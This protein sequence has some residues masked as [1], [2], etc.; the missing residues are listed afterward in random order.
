MKSGDLN[1]PKT[2]FANLLLDAFPDS[3]PRRFAF[4]LKMGSPNVVSS[5]NARPSDF[6]R[7]KSEPVKFPRTESVLDCTL[8]LEN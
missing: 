2:P 6:Q 1:A 4:L 5:V 8:N 3:N 7:F